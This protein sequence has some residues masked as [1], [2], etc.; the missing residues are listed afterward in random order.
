MYL[1]NITIKQDKIS[2]EKE[3][4]LLTKHREWF[5]KYFKEGKFLLLGPYLDKQASGIIIAYEENRDKLEKIL[6]EDIYYSGLADYEVREF[7]ANM[8]SDKLTDFQG[9]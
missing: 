9:K 1:V 5:A 8:V 3:D 2:K 6:S 7:K 4:E